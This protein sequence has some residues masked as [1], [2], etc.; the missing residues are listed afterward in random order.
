MRMF[1]HHAL[2]SIGGCVVA[3]K[4]NVYPHIVGNMTCKCNQCSTTCNREDI[5]ALSDIR[6][7]IILLTGDM[8]LRSEL[9]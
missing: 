9:I 8:L 5:L 1:S 4:C 3:V 6:Q 7:C 2:V